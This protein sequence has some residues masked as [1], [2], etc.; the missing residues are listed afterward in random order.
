MIGFGSVF[1]SPKNSFYDLKT[2]AFFQGV[3][4]RKYNVIKPMN[5]SEIKSC[6]FILKM[7]IFGFR[8]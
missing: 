3:I 8:N 6:L 7:S 4:T 2:K 1:D 5:V